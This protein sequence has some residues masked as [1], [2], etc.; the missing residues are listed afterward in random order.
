MNHL[1][2]NYWRDNDTALFILKHLYRDIPEDC[3]EPN[4]TDQSGG[5]S[6]DNQRQ[7]AGR[8]YLSDNSYDE[9]LPLTFS[10]KV[11]I[12]EFSRKARKVMKSP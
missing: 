5:Q 4:S 3:E 8:Y 10:D 11:F 12:K 2:R 1:C 7:S 6:S 9:D